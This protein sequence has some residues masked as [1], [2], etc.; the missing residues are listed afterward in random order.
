MPFTPLP[1]V[2]T[3][4]NVCIH[5]QMSL[6]RQNWSRGWVQAFKWRTQHGIWPK[7]A[8]PF[9]SL[10]SSHVI[11]EKLRFR[12][13]QFFIQDCE[14]V[15]ITRS[16]RCSGRKCK[17]RRQLQFEAGLFILKKNIRLLPIA[18]SESMGLQH[19]KGLFSSAWNN[20]WMSK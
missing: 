15:T 14:L 9:R 18:T 1:Q 6:E 19:A 17:S 12:K 5:C 8:W 11:N 4:Q 3:T 2:V 7:I 16:S 20:D 13:A 10:Q